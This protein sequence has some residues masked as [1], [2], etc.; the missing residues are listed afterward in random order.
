MKS[1]SGLKLGA[2]V[3]VLIALFVVINLTGFSENIRGF[4]YSISSPIQKNLWSAGADVSGFFSGIFRQNE[5]KS[6]NENLRAQNSQLLLQ[7]ANL[8]DLEKENE[9]LR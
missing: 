4:F 6:E 9:A 8:N 2:L 1:R 7:L 3:V 5:L